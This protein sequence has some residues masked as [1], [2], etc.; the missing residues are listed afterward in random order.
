MSGH[1][2]DWQALTAYCNKLMQ[3][4]NVP[5]DEAELIADHLVE[6]ELYGVLSHGVSRTSIYLKRLKEG[7][8]NPRWSH[9]VEQEY[10]ATVQ[11]NACNSMGMVTGCL[12]YTSFKCGK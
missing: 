7:V 11:W 3:T 4:Q 9:Q 1:V 2:V 12:L 6:A 10:A 8:V 5:E